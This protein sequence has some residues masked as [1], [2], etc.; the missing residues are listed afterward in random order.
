MPKLLGLKTDS[1][2]MI[3]LD[4][5]RFVASAGI[6][7]YHSNEFFFSPEARPA[8]IAG[9]SLGLFVDLFFMISGFVMAFVYK[10]RLSTLK[11]YG[12]FLW[13][14]VAR[15]YPLHLVVLAIN[16]AVWSVVLLKASPETTPSFDPMCILHTALLVQ[17]YVDCGSP[18]SFNGVTWSISI[19]MG[20]YVV[21]PIF[22]FLALAGSAWIGAASLVTIAGALY[23]LPA[24]MNWGHLPG[25]VRGAASF[26]I[27]V[28]V[29]NIRN[30]LPNLG[31]KGVLTP[32]LTAGLFAAMMTGVPDPL[33]MA[34]M[35]ALFVVAVSSD[36]HGHAASWVRTLSPLGQLTYSM[37]IWHRIIILMFMNI[38][39]DKLMP[40]NVPIL[41]AMT[42]LTYAVIFAV[43]YVGY[44]QIE[45][46]A[47]RALT[48]LPGK[49]FASRS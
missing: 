24:D 22:V 36:L 20:L 11:S 10:D 33:T 43:S 17:E 38:A 44:F 32:L 2:H 15:L 35:L 12:D 8:L 49:I 45:Q 46:R 25:W 13:R 18:Y 27:G 16:I 42:A 21:F 37:Y 9:Q 41:I 1:D 30:R 29:F 14:R 28:F 48:K 47:R 39:A 3:S 31:D 4:F 40:G 26:P 7:Y 19:E 6:V 34:L 5:L 23:F